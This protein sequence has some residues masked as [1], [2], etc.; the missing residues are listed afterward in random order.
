MLPNYLILTP[1]GVGSTY[2]QRALTVYLN[3]AGKDY[4]NPHELLNGLQLKNDMLLRKQDAS[5]NWLYEYSQTVEDIC[6]MLQ[7]AKNKL[8]CRIAKYHITQRLQEYDHTEDYEKF[9]Q[10]CNK[11]FDKKLFCTRDPFEYAMSW[12]IRNKTDMLNM[13]TVKDR[14]DMHFSMDVDVNFFKQKLSEYGA[15]EFWVK[16]NFTNLV[17]VDYDRFHHN[18]DNELHNITGY[19]HAVTSKFDISLKDYGILRYMFSKEHNNKNYKNDTIFRQQYKK[20]LTLHE[21]ISTLQ[22]ESKMDTWMPIKMR[23]M[24]D[25]REMVTNFD[26]MIEVYNLWAETTNMHQPVT[27]ETIQDKITQEKKLYG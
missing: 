17:A 3:C 8:V 27:E 1:D 21:Y 9:Y 16:D 20:V 23:T 11:V 26:Q 5:H 4:Y 14:K 18:P 22:S 6:S 15:Y 10:V 24:E 7:Q 13:Y 12:S 2:L 25:K 19:E